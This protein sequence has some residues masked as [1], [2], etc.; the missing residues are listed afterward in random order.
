M[1]VFIS[2]ATF[3]Y[4]ILNLRWRQLKL[5][6]EDKNLS[7]PPDLHSLCDKLDNLS[8][9][10]SYFSDLSQK[11]VR[12]FQI[13]LLNFVPK[14]FLHADFHSLC[15]KWDHLST[16]G[17]Y[18]LDLFQKVVRFSAIYFFSSKYVLSPANIHSICYKLD[19]LSSAGLYFSALATKLDS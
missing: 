12:F 15:H 18:F 16:A 2:F 10:G 4:I 8:T 5:T 11:V 3:F 19:H 13:C 9:A 1:N 7:S 17:P 14:N 6:E